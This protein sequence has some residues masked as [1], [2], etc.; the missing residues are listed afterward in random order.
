MR[1]AVKITALVLFPLILFIFRVIDKSEIDMA[2]SLVKTIK[3][4]FRGSRKEE[5]Q[6]P[7]ASID[8]S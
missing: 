6:T 3:E 7:V 2:L 8:E 4:F 1:I 5:I